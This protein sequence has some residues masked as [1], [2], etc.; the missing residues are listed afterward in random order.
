MSVYVPLAWVYGAAPKLAWITVQP[1]RYIVPAA[2]TN[3]APA[4]FDESG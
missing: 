4:D 1:E 3:N 2:N